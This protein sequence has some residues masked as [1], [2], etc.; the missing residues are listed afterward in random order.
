MLASILRVVTFAAHLNLLK[1]LYSCLKDSVSLQV[2]SLM[3]QFKRVNWHDQGLGSKV[4]TH[5]PFAAS[6]ICHKMT[7]QIWKEPKILIR[8]QLFN[9]VLAPTI[10]YGK[11][12]G[13]SGPLENPKLGTSM[14]CFSLGPVSRIQDYMKDKHHE[15]TNVD[16]FTFFD[17]VDLKFA[18]LNLAKQECHFYSP[19]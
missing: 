15:M 11:K 3:T 12:P 16:S 4:A 10:I 19:F 6:D 5:R 1:G 9:E 7:H 17:Q 8:K 13:R 18:Q 14:D 2:P